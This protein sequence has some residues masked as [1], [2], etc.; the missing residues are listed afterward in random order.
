MFSELFPDSVRE[1]LQKFTVGYIL[2]QP[3]DIIDFSV[4]YF[5]KLKK[6]RDAAEIIKD[7]SSI[8]TDMESFIDYDKST[9]VL[10]TTFIDT[11]QFDSI[12]LEMSAKTEEQKQILSAVLQK[13]LLFNNLENDEI[14]TLINCMYEKE[15]VSNEIIFEQNVVDDK[16][17]IIE[18]GVFCV[19][20]NGSVAN[21][22]KELESFGEL[23]LL[24]NY[25]RHSTVQCKEG[26][27]L[28]VLNRK[29]FRFIMFHMSRQKVDTYQNHLEH[30]PIF[31]ILSQDE[32]EKI[33][34][35]MSIK[36]FNAG[37]CI[38]AEGEVRNG[39]HFIVDGRVSLR[40]KQNYGTDKTMVVLKPGQYFGELALITSSNHLVSAYSITNVKTVFLCLMAF[41]RL[42]G[43]GVQLFNRQH[44]K[45]E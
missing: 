45:E 27:K 29:S 4:E 30:L 15:T 33:S 44:N 19:M 1:I 11:E 41:E 42:I 36:R 6:C 43:S 17:Y 22:F 28:W 9:K 10:E 34:E 26:G 13:S 31:R 14:D 16:F 24:Y 25:P 32:R 12:Q 40:V 21:I 20:N 23:A 35:A 5:T 3:S 38:L 37:Q 7:H 18:L 2:E 39:I 8:F